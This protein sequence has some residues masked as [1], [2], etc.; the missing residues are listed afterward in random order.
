MGWLDALIGGAFSYFSDRSEERQQEAMDKDTYKWS[1]RLHQYD[2]RLE[3]YYRRKDKAERRRGANEY[4]KFSSLSRW[5][6]GYTNTFTPD[7]VGDEP[8]PMDYED[9]DDD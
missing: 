7:P 1:S 4:A 3:D 8:A 9:E 5:A 2:A 6:P